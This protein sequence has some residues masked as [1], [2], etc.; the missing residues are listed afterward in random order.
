[1]KLESK[2]ADEV[3]NQFS[4]ILNLIYKK[5]TYNSGIEMARHEIIKKNW[6]KNLLCT[7]I[8]FLGKR[9]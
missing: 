2:K 7:P 8:C 4:K 3:A 1:M 6:Y 5:M 9:Y